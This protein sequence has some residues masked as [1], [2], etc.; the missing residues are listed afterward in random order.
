MRAEAHI[1]MLLAAAL[2]RPASSVPCSSA[3]LSSGG[4]SLL[5]E[6]RAKVT[7]ESGGGEAG[8]EVSLRVL[9]VG[10]GGD[11]D[12]FSGNAGG[13]GFL[14]FRQVR[15]L[16]LSRLKRVSHLRSR[17]W[18]PPF[19]L[20]MLAE[21]ETLE[22]R[23]VP[24]P[25]L[26]TRGGKHLARLQGEG[27][28]ETASWQAELATVEEGEAASRAILA[29]PGAQMVETGNILLSAV[30]GELAADWTSPPYSLTT[31]S[32]CRGGEGRASTIG[33]VG[34]AES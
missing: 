30:T 10:G 31:S 26:S 17:L 12:A 16:E 34:V 1:L 27:E 29:G 25:S 14:E 9:L 11:G 7:V 15:E 21:M 2:T 24:A 4:S 8:C 19:S 20:W 3:S 18:P 5:A 28:E 13:S 32:W 23:A 33:L 22:E 6:T